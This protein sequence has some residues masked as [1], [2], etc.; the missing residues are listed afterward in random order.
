[1]TS[2]A[3]L[4][5]RDTSVAIVVCAIVAIA[6]AVIGAVAVLIV[7][8]LGE[9]DP[10]AD[11]QQY[12]E[13]TRAAH[14]L[15]PSGPVLSDPDG[16]TRAGIGPFLAKKEEARRA[17]WASRRGSLETRRSRR[18]DVGP[19]VRSLDAMSTPAK[20]GNMGVLEVPGARLYYESVGSG[21][22]LVLVPG[23]NGTAHIFGALAQ[24]L[25]EHYTVI[26]YDRR[27]FARS[28]L[29]G[30]Q[31]YE[32]RLQTDADDVR[33]VIE[34]VATA[35]ATVFGPSS[36]AIVVLEALTRHP[37]VM[38]KVVA[39]EPPAMK[40]LPDGRRWLDFFDDVYDIYS[41][42]GIQP[43]LN[44]FNQKTFAVEDQAFFARL[45]D[46]S[47]PAVRDS[48]VYWF[49]H[50]LRQYTR[51]DFDLDALKAQRDRITVA[52]GRA[53]RGYPLHGVCTELARKLSQDV[54]ELPGG[55]TG[56][57][58]HADEFASALLDL[59]AGMEAAAAA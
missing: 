17:L 15:I 22:P 37:S 40:Q 10:V 56:Y 28:Q 45:R 34:Q 39:Y 12:I 7:F 46:V 47:K 38:D 5:A 27:G 52:A 57:A 19:D 59:L 36:G 21:P 23:G 48:V 31:E 32:R 30:A 53:S 18:R 25:A 41:K 14:R 42:S 35:P 2:I 24:R 58:T 33:Q 13:L 8:A 1:V 51:V 26:T 4:I 29:D 9:G 54:V 44:A 6:S 3:F 49:E 16:Q 20:G 11:V 43:A 55:H 50:E